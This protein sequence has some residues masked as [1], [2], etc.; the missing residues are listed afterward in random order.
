MTDA[1]LVLGFG[2]LA[3]AF[4]GC[5]FWALCGIGRELERINTLLAVCAEYAITRDAAGDM[6]MEVD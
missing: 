4:L 3:A 2:I 1:Y 6:E 5:I